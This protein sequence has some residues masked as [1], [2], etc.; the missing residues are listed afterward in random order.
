[1]TGS[2]LDPAVHLFTHLAIAIAIGGTAGDARDR[3]QSRA[4]RAG[5]PGVPRRGERLRASCRARACRASG[6]RGRDGT[7]DRAAPSGSGHG[8]SI[9]ISSNPSSA[10][11]PS[12]SSAASTPRARSRR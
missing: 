12:A 2:P 11:G 5:R 1:M 10:T 6:Q 3:P 7:E 8:G 4:P 9:A